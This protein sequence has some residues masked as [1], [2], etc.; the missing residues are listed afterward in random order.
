MASRNA[1]VDLPLKAR[2]EHV[3]AV[4][5]DCIRVV[6]STGPVRERLLAVGTATDDGVA[7]AY[8][9]KQALAAA[10]SHLQ[11]LQLPFGDA[12]GGWP[13]A[14]VFCQL[15]DAGLVHGPIRT[16]T[17]SRPDQPALGI[18]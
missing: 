18:G 9:S 12:P 5:D 7:I 13:P 15:R 3:E 16:I 11:S 1:A 6:C 10:L 14:A 8:T 4:L 2:L 17:W